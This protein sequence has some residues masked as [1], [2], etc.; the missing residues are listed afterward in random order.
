MVHLDILRDNREQKPWSFD[1]YPVEVRGETINTGDYT[2]AEFCHHDPDNDTYHPRYAIERKGGDDFINSITR[3][4]ERFKKEIKRA[5]DWE[6]PLLVLIE[7]PKV[8][9]KR[10][11]GF[12]QYRDISASQIF[13]TVGTWE[14][15]YN[16]DFEFAG[17]RD[18]CQQM[19]F[20]ALASRLRAVLTS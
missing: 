2:L 15:H 7:E 14:R 12:M 3:D 6:C 5:S 20:D 1:N 17:T 10:G 4:R 11:D 16:V 13:G 18:R 19:A 9:F 8:T